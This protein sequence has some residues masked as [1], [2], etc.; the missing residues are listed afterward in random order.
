M[1]NNLK[2]DYSFYYE[3]LQPRF[4]KNKKPKKRKFFKNLMNRSQR[5][6]SKS[7]SE[8]ILKSAFLVVFFTLIHLQ[9]F[10]QVHRVETPYIQKIPTKELQDELKRRDQLKLTLEASG[11]S[12]ELIAYDVVV[13]KDLIKSIATGREAEK[14][15]KFELANPYGDRKSITFDLDIHTIYKI[16]LEHQEKQNK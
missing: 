8:S 9:G 7:L 14:K 6:F 5:R 12:R 16:L 4:I 10:G 1:K 3:I 13:T 15:L 2:K 11:V